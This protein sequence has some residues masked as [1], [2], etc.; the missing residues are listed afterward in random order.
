MGLTPFGY[1]PCAIAGAI[2][3]VFGFDK[4]RKHLPDPDDVMLDLFSVFCRLC[5]HFLENQ[6]P[7]WPDRRNNGEENLEDA[8]CTVKTDGEIMSPTWITAYESYNKKPPEL[9]KY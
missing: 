1:Y 9:T 5:G 8:E 6:R 7:L 3:R 4:G 2:D